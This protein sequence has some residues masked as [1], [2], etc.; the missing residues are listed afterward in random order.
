M[1][2]CAANY[3]RR[4]SNAKSNHDPY[5]ENG[6]FI[7]PARPH[8]SKEIRIVY[9]GLLSNSGASQVYA[10]IGLGAEWKK[11]RQIK[12]ERRAEGFEAMVPTH[13]ASALHVAF[14]DAAENWDNNN[15]NNYV[16]SLEET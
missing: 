14:H 3:V 4:W 12:M 10:H 7:R 1:S 11:T 13:H 5:P 2:L 8:D 9:N 15:G 6:V 16:F